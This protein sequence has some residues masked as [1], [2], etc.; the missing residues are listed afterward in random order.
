M[1][2]HCVAGKTLEVGGGSGNLDVAYFD[3]VVSTDIVQLPWLDV[4]ADA[5]SLPFADMCFENV[6]AIDVLHHIERPVR[7]LKEASR[8]LKPGGRLVLLEPGITPGSRLFYSLFH[9]EPVDF[10][11]DP[12][13]DGPLSPDRDPFDANQAVATQLIGKY[14]HALATAVPQ[15]VMHETEWMSLLAYPL[16]GG[17]RPWALLPGS[18]VGTLLKLEDFVMPLFGRVAAYRLLLVLERRAA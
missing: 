10:K 14:R 15:L 11:A 7:F 3:E 1:A 16:S 4:A 5:Q 17:F 13:A 18:L 6:I 8:V 2:A 9:P 12:L